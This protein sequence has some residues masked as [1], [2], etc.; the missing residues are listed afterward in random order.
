MD[1]P[2]NHAGEPPAI[3]V[4]EPLTGYTIE[5]A[6]QELGISIHEDSRDRIPVVGPLSTDSFISKAGRAVGRPATR[7]TTNHKDGAYYVQ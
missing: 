3:F 1:T 7:S 2:K 4:D 5:A 6:E